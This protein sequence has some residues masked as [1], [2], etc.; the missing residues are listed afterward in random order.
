MKVADMEARLDNLDRRLDRIEQILPTLASK[1]DLTGFATKAE[2]DQLQLRTEVLFESLR[3]DIRL[4]AEGVASLA[5][6]F[7]S[8]T[9]RFGSMTDQVGSLTTQVSSLMRLSASGVSFSN[10]SLSKPG[11]R[12]IRSRGTSATRVSRSVSELS[13]AWP[14]GSR[15]CFDLNQPPASTTT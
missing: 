3:D 14:T 15:K 7:A 1:A 9:E 11:K 2:F 8:L 10:S 12:S 6:Q 13:R 4:V 5:S